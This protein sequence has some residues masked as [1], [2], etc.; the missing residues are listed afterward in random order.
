MLDTNTTPVPTE[1]TASI[2]LIGMAKKA[3]TTEHEALEPRAEAKACHERACL[4]V[5]SELQGTASNTASGHAGPAGEHVN[6]LERVQLLDCQ[7]KTT[8]DQ[9]D[10]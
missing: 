7:Q 5:K 4:R 8:F 6:H 10:V 9:M 1:G 2:K 3:A